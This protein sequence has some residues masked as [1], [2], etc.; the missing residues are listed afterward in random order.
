MLHAAA[1]GADAA[2]DRES[3]CPPHAAGCAHHVW[4]ERRCL[5][6]PPCSQGAGCGLWLFLREE[7]STRN[8]AVCVLGVQEGRS[9]RSAASPP[10]HVDIAPLRSRSL[11]DAGLAR[12]VAAFGIS[13][14]ARGAG[15]ADETCACSPAG[16]RE[17][18]LDG[19]D[20]APDLVGIS[21]R[22]FARCRRQ[23]GLMRSRCAVTAAIG[24]KTRAQQRFYG[25][26]G[27]DVKTE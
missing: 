25:G 19:A 23:R 15:A 14:S 7:C 9:R 2:F 1:L 10:G 5:E 21:G 20:N 22:A 6:A 18:A 26:I 4:A 8:P 16:R 17:R 11:R 27:A 13:R 24:V 3:R 12:A